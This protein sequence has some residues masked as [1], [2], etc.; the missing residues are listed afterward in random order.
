MTRQAGTIKIGIVGACGRGASFK[1]ACDAAEGVQVLAV[2]D[3][4]AEGL[5]AA[6]QRLGASEQY[7]DYETML[8]RSEIDAV[9]IGT[10]MP[11]HV[12]QAIAALQRGKHVLSEVPAGVS[13]EECRELTLTAHASSGIYMMA[14]NY[15]YIKSNVL[16]RE[17]VRQGL[18]GTTYYAEGEYLHELKELNEITRWRRKW[19]TGINGNT[20]PTHS[21]GPILQWMPGDRVVSVC[22]VGS[23]HHY[24]D[25]RGDLYENEDSTI[26]LCKMRSGGLVKLR[27]DMLSD[28]PHLMTGY[29]LQGTDGAYESARAS[30]EEDRVWLRALSRDPN[31]WTPLRELEAEYLPAMWREAS[32]VA[33]RAGHGGGDYF[34]VMDFIAAIRGERPP[35]IDI[36]MAMDMT[37]PGLISQRS[38]AEGGR[39]LEVPDSR[40][41]LTETPPQPQLQMRFPQRLFH[42]LP[43]PVVPDGYLLRNLRPGEEA[44]YSALMEKAGF[45]GWSIEQVKRFMQR[46]LPGGFFVVEH[47]AT[48]ALVATAMANHAPSEQHPN[49]GVLDWVAAD[50]DHKG[51]GL[52]RAVTAAVVRLL[53]ERGYQDIYLLTDDWRLPALKTYLGLGWEP[54]L[55][56]PEMEARWQRVYAALDRR[57]SH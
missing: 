36:H 55:L 17:L 35:E 40:A 4:N 34:E 11:L 14:E 50:P 27:L 16:V 32:E 15:T 13:V 20:Y 30:G 18:F 37:L 54:I 25:P 43:I 29:Q 47:L 19:Q 56:T 51:R 24:R 57:E 42:S 44:A 1:S 45:G 38:I 10:P 33:R 3:T 49:A 31:R 6:A 48:G 12:P 21:L 5:P 39:W 23:G 53:V 52:G 8:E 9:I 41:W 46:V 22:C 28:R 2:C 7:T 26:T